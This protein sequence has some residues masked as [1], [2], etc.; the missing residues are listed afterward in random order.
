MNERLLQYIWQFQYFNRSQLVTSDGESLFIILPGSSNSN[1]GPDFLDAKIKLGNTTWVGNI[2]LHV[3]SSDWN[4]HKH[5]FD[6]N[7]GN[8]ILHVVWQN[9]LQVDMPFPVLE[10]NTLVSKILLAKFEALMNAHSFIACAPIVDKVPPVIW[11]AWKERLLVE[12]LQKKTIIIIQYLAE[13]NNHWE[14]VFWWLIA[15][16]FGITVNSEAFEKM[17]RS[18]PVGLLAKHKNQLH[19]AEALLFGQAGLLDNNFNDEYPKMLQKEYEF[20]KKKYSLQ[21]IHC[22]LHFLRMR[23]SN[24]PTVRLSQLAMLVHHSTRLFS[25]VKEAYLLEDV[26]KLLSVTANDYWHYHYTFDD[27]SSFKEKSLGMQMINSIIINTI[28]PVVF[29]Y[30]QHN[31]E[32]AYK[33]KALR[34]LEQT[35]AEK[36]HITNGFTLLGIS[37]K[38]AFDS[39][40]LIQLKNEYCNVKR[41]LECAIGNRLLKPQKD[42]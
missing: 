30:G 33:E 22:P 27:A 4:Q 37:N 11:M 34:W 2:E 14:E 15:R 35:L 41:C 8:I 20:Y 42:S 1:Q 12:R 9:D 23:P 38:N 16:N 36:N 21:P 3:L 39:Q 6:K 40:G 19:Q 17:A 10:L 31:G 5:S 28:V 7:Y 13:N 18:L 25:I 32:N 26:K 29:A 24:F